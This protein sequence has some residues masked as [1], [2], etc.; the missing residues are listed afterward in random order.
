NLLLPSGTCREAQRSAPARLKSVGRFFR[1]RLLTLHQL[2]VEAERLQLA[3]EHVERFG[4]ARFD[5]RLALDDGLVNLG[6]AINVVG[7]CREEFLQDVRGA[8]GFE[9]PDF[10]F[11][12]ALAAELRLAAEGLLRNQ[13]IGADGTRVN[14]VVNEVRQLEHVDETDG[15]R[16]IE[17]VAGHAV[18]EI[19]LAGVRESRD[20]QQVADFGFARAVEHGRGEGNSVAEAF[21]VVEQLLIGHLGERL[22]DG[23]VAENFAEPA[24]ERFG[25]DFLAEQAFETVAK[26]LGSPAEVRFENLADVHTGR[27]AEGVEHDFHGRAVGKV[28]HVFLRHDA[29]DDALVT[30][31]AGHFVA[32]GELALHGDINLGQLDDP[33]RQLVALLELFLALLGDLAEHVDLPGGHLLDLFDLFDQERILFVELQ[34]FEV[35]RGDLFDEVAGKFG[36]LDQ[37]TLVGLFVV[38]VGL[39]YLAAQQIAEALEALIG[40]DAD[41]VGEVLFQLEDLRGFDGLVTFVLFATLAGED[42]D[43]NDGAFDARRAIERSVANIAGLFAEDGAEKLLLRREGGFALGRDLADEDVAGLD[44]GADADDAAFVEVAQE[45][46]ADVGDIARNFLGAELGVARFDFVLL[47]MD[48]GVVIVL[49]ELFADE[50]GVFKVVAAP[51]HKGDKHVTA[52]AEF[53]AVSARPVGEDLSGPDAITHANERLL[54]DAS[55]LV[56]ALELG[57]RV[58]VRAHFAAE[59]AGVVAFDADDDAFRIDLIND[60]IALAED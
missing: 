46:F 48:G 45:R 42:L 21:G 24:A 37:Q 38:Q 53:A 16:L 26:F 40:E 3:N 15:D 12:E 47:D 8:I 9:G 52:E 51:G 14:L 7:L 54:V 50:D 49:D 4:N 56:G 28:R 27:N 13:R 25:F 43:V 22:P 20:F 23:R 6:A 11:A 39:Q 10:H 36:A 30:V 31:A 18:E 34:T 59:D 1:R 29:G 60:A 44:H 33:R 19:D 55:I 2:D 17:L 57:K 35:A 5:A 32:D 41:F 58:D